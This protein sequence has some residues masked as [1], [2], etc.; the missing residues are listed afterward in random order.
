MS[1]RY[2]IEALLRPPVEWTSAIAAWS[3][4]ALAVSAPAAMLMTPTV[5]YASAVFLM[6]S[7]LRCARHVLGATIGRSS[8]LQKKK[9]YNACNLTTSMAIY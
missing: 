4:A 1:G 9:V 7:L 2:P 5:G 8:A 6:V 3:V